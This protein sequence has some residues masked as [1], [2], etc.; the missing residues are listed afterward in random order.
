MYLV[1]GRG[2]P[3]HP[4]PFLFLLKGGSHT[5][6]PLYIRIS[7]RK[8]LRKYGRRNNIP[9]AGTFEILCQLFN[10]IHARSSRSSRILWFFFFF[11]LFLSR[12]STDL[13]ERRSVT[14]REE[15][16]QWKFSTRI[17]LWRTKIENFSLRFST[18]W[19][20]EETLSYWSCINRS[21]LGRGGC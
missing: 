7:R 10:T 6:D 17:L 18:R 13:L 19:Q 3:S 4:L 5:R 14:I 21:T 12:D 16:I 1:A 20:C 15:S 9:D 11:S 8:R 2:V